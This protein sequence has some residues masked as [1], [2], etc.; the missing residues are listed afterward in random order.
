M[1]GFG[2]LRAVADLKYES[3]K[4]MWYVCVHCPPVHDFSPDLPRQQR[5][6]GV[7]PV[8]QLPVALGLDQV[9][10]GLGHNARKKGKVSEM[11]AIT[12]ALDVVWKR[13]GN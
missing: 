12:E 6:Y 8:V 4:T 7:Q 11:G 5:V 2:L 1:A 13:A 3:E 9:A 10:L